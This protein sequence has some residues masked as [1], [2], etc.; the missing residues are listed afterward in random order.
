MSFSVRSA[1]VCLAALA[2]GCMPMMVNSPMIQG[3]LRLVSAGYTG[4]VPEDNV[5]TNVSATMDGSGSWNA[6]CKGKPYL[7]TS[8]GQV[9]GG[10]QYHC[11]PVAQ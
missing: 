8:V 11:A 1:I 9:D 2:G 3:K 7:C 6:S 10:A 5:L 4:C